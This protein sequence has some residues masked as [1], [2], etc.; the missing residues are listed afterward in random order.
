MKIIAVAVSSILE[1]EEEQDAKVVLDEDES[2]E[3]ED[4]LYL[5]SPDRHQNST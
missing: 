5:R 1:A 4:D 2:N 3:G